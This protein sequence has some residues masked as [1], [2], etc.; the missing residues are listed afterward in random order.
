MYFSSQGSA[1]FRLFYHFK[2]EE[3]LQM[4]KKHLRLVLLKYPNTSILKAIGLFV[5]EM[6]PGTSIDGYT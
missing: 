3:L 4:L 5:V 1:S 6:H 2:F